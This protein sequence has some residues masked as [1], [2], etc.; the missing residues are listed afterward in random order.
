[1]L[2][3]W[4]V[5]LRAVSHFLV[6]YFISLPHVCVHLLLS[7]NSCYWTVLVLYY[8]LMEDT[9]VMNINEVT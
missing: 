9:G 7:K 1:M 5:D 3:S 4:K 8:S 6:N 2:P